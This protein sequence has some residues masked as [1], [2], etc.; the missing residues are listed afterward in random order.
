MVQASG[1]V[2]VWAPFESSS[3]ASSLSSTLSDLHF[4]CFVSRLCF[5]ELQRGKFKHKL[6]LL[7]FECC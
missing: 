3:D 1:L 7:V 4:S 2:Q 6:P 5:L